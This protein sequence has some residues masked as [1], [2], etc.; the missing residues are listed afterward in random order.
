VTPKKKLVDVDQALKFKITAD[1]K[2]RG[3]QEMRNDLGKD[4]VAPKAAVASRLKQL[5]TERC[6]KV[7]YIGNFPI[8][9]SSDL[10]QLRT[11]LGYQST[12]RTQWS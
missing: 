6:P 11:T 1:V 3:H 2:T 7:S 8:T 10:L 12:A 4:N 9:C 5:M